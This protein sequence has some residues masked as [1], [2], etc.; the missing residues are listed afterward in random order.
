METKKSVN[1]ALLRAVEDASYAVYVIIGCIADE[2]ARG[3]LSSNW[4]NMLSIISHFI[5]NQK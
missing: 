2:E 4:E 3:D 1:P 5:P